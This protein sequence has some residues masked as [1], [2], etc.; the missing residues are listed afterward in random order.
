M[1]V[2][3]AAAMGLVLVMLTGAVSLADDGQGSSIQGQNTVSLGHYSF[4][5][6]TNGSISN[7]TYVSDEISQL[8]VYSMTSTGTNLSSALGN[9][10]TDESTFVN[11]ANMTLTKAGDS[12]T[13]L[14]LTAGSSTVPKPTIR[15]SVN[16]TLSLTYVRS[17]MNLSSQ[18]G[19]SIIQGFSGATWSVYTITNPAFTGYFFTNGEVT[20]SNGNS[21]LSDTY[22]TSSGVSSFFTTKHVLVAGFVSHGS[23]EALLQKY[24]KEHEHQD[25]F[26]YNATTQMVTGKF[27][28]FKFDSATGEVSSYSRNGTT[29]MTIFTSINV[30][31][32]G[33]IGSQEDFPSFLLDHVI[34]RGSIFYYANKTF[35]YT[36]HNNPAMN[37]ALVVDNGTLNLTLSPYLNVTE[38]SATSVQNLEL[39]STMISTNSSVQ[40]NDVLDTDHE[41]S[42]GNTNFVIYG[43]GVR[44][45]LSVHGN[46]TYNSDKKTITVSS[47]HLAL[48]NFVS[49]PGLQGEDLKDF[50][51]IQN[52]ILHGK[53]GGEVSISYESGAPFNYTLLYNNS[54]HVAVTNVTSG[55]VTVQVS[56][57]EHAGTHIVFFVNSS[58]VSSTGKLYVYF[59]GKSATVS[60]LNG[61]LNVTTSTNAVY[62]VVNVT[63]G[64]LVIVSIPHFSNHTIVI[65]DTSLSP[66]S[67]LTGSS[68][69]YKV[70]GIVIV[71]AI[72]GTAF[73]LRRNRK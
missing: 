19:S 44:A 56:S 17:S 53:I 4:A 34:L 25:K 60:S 47:K 69:T 61:T 68:I 6:D 70:V 64:Y 2:K 37:F 26:S 11:T 21:T 31:G 57:T 45:F 59:D 1:N 7:I 49:P 38:F 66:V 51:S 15:A 9:M 73:A 10:Q 22:A 23:I 71:A 16:G 5:T 40:Q 65:S 58:F 67:P 8:F 35:V 32:N 50:G 12:S 36:F 43:D 46:A 24:E 42:A 13:L 62:A 33:T 27:V 39:N 63:G 3:I 48:V 72:V 14:V 18:D 52:A 54:L 41:T 29:P 20:L 28:N 55:K 30:S